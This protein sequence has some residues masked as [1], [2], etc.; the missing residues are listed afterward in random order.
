MNT[1]PTTL[2]SLLADVSP[3]V[4]AEVF[5]V[6]QE[7]NPAT[8][9]LI[10]Q[11]TALKLKHEPSGRTDRRNAV[12]V[13]IVLKPGCPSSL[14]SVAFTER[15]WLSMKL[16]QFGRQLE[17]GEESLRDLSPL[18]YELGNRPEGQE[19][20][21]GRSTSFLQT[22]GLLEELRE[23]LRSSDPVERI[24]S[25]NEDV[26]GAYVTRLD[27]QQ[28]LF[29]ETAAIEGQVVLYWAVIGL[30]A[31]LLGE[32]VEALTTLV[33]A[34]ELSHAYT[35]LGADIDGH[36][37]ATEDFMATDDALLECLAQYY[38]HRVLKRSEWDGAFGVYQRLLERQPPNYREHLPLVRDSKPEE[39]RAAM[40]KVRRQG[41]RRLGAMKRLLA[42]E[43][44]ALRTVQ[45]ESCSLQRDS[46]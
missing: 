22:M 36:R 46:H 8:R 9:E 27:R 16:S 11:E 15:D 44:D 28:S 41:H 45:P 10:R 21:Q 19:V 33:L 24:L 32:S 29:G 13:P 12:S 38:T 42:E 23:S 1:S 18:I 40:L 3:D 39:V 35:H 14:S 25:V 31:D 4:E 37:W 30:T 26:L 6:Q 17:Q 34:H 20:L 2:A 5:R 43:R 7:R